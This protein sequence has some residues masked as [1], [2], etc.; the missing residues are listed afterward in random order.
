MNECEFCKEVENKDRVTLRES[1]MWFGCL[2]NASVELEMT[3]SY[4]TVWF[5]CDNV[6]DAIHP[7]EIKIGY[8][9]MCG[10]KFEGKGNMR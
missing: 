9:P 8:C 4:L 2:G 1:T 10:R 3:E 5:D 7:I 6:G